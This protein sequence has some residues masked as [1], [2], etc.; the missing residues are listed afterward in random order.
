MSVDVWP[1]LPLI[2]YGGHVSETIMD[3][4][5]PKLRHSN[6]ISYIDIA[7][8]TISQIETVLAAMQ[9][10]FP[11]LTVLYLSN[12]I[13]NMAP[14]LPNS[15]LGGSA[16][17]MRH[18]GLGWIAFPGLSNLLLSAAHLV[19]LRLYD[20]P[21][22]GYISPEAMAACLS[23]LTSLEKL[24]LIFVSPQSSP[25][26]ENRHSPPPT[27]SIL[28][29]LTT[30]WFKGAHEYLEDLVSRI[31]SPQLYLLSARFFNDIDYDTPELN[32]FIKIG[33]AHV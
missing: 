9:V 28:P 33:R 14:V 30:I 8:S 1:A 29:A 19:T 31:D 13:P 16:P 32:Q 20:I 5:A 3:E 6:R 26:Q 22:S 18:L 17:R 7:C 10:P 21:H 4:I 27:R 12:L 2:I 11:E 23:T 25:D 15:F 24:R